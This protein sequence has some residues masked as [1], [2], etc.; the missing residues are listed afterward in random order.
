MA[1]K[2]NDL[3]TERSKRIRHCSEDTVRKPDF[4]GDLRTNE[5]HDVKK[6]MRRIRRTREKHL[7]K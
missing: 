1:Q 5:N 3:A 4:E 7:R 2:I 6:E